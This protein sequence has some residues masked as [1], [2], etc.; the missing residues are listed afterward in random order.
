M[1][2]WDHDLDLSAARC[3]LGCARLP[4]ATAPGVMGGVCQLFLSGWDTPMLSASHG[5][6]LASARRPGERAPAED[7]RVYVE[8]RLASP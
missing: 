6:G 4:T 1:V 3:L 7:V 8:H 2:V 5:R